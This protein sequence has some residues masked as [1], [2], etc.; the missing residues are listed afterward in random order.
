MTFFRNFERPCSLLFIGP[1]ILWDCAQF[2]DNLIS[3]AALFTHNLISDVSNILFRN[4][5][6]CR[7]KTLPPTAQSTPKFK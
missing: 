7:V 6:I 4:C 2:C 3:A 1:L 5:E